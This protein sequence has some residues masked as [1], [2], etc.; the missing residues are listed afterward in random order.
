ML[1]MTIALLFQTPLQSQRPKMLASDKLFYFFK[2]TA[3][4]TKFYAN[5]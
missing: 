3:E 2:P 1:K 4:Y 5:I